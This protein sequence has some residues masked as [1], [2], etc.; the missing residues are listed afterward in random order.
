[1]E[2]RFQEA[3]NIFFGKNMELQSFHPFPPA[4]DRNAY[5]LLPDELKQRLIA[6]GEACLDSPYPPVYAT[7]FMS[8]KRTG[9]RVNFENLYF[10]RRYNLNSLVLAECTE[11]KGRFLD[12]IINGI[13]VLCE[14]SAW[15]LDRKSVV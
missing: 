13:F 10:K 7:D 15:Q 2:V 9:N 4:S 6:A 14:E 12:Q 8:F 5:N 1:M 11:A 3:A